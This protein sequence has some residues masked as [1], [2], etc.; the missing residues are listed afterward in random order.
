MSKGRLPGREI[1]GQISGL[2][3]VAAIGLAFVRSWAADALYALVAPMWI[4]PDRRI[5]RKIG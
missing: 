2:L 4:V 1:K 3:Y 5:E